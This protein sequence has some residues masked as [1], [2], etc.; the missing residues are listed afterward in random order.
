ME[1]NIFNYNLHQRINRKS[2]F[3]YG[4]AMATLIDAVKSHK[5]FMQPEHYEQLSGRVNLTGMQVQEKTRQIPY[6]VLFTNGDYKFRKN[7]QPC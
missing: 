2:H 3:V 6:K 5:T 7:T 1:T 4:W